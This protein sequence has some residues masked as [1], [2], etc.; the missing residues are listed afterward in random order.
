M[1]RLASIDFGTGCGARRFD[2][3]ALE[4]QLGGTAKPFD[5]SRRVVAQPG[6]GSAAN[7]FIGTPLNGAIFKDLSLANANFANVSLAQAKFDDIDFSNT[8]ITEQLQFQGHADRRGRRQ[9]PFRRLRKTSLRSIEVDDAEENSHSRRPGR[10]D[11]RVPGRFRLGRHP[12]RGRRPPRRRAIARRG[13][14][15]TDRRRRHDRAARHHRCPHLPV[16]DG[17]ARLCA[18][19]VAGRLL[20]EV[21]AVAQPL[22]GRR[23]LQC[24]LSRRLRNAVLRHDHRR[25]LL[26][27]HQRARLRPRLDRGVEGNRHPPPLHLFLH[28]CPSGPVSAAGGPPGRRPAGP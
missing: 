15:R 23:Q 25:R 11:G 28:A 16:A 18:R 4:G 24:S 19:P 13:R 2:L 17:A 9:R 8:V 1:R 5:P 20:L 22:H 12:G 27:Q 26:P 10:H 21:P 6:H 3:R 14:R 7:V